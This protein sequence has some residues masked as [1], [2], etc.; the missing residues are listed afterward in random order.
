[1]AELMA[2]SPESSA[3]FCDLAVAWLDATATD[4]VEDA[5]RDI[6]GDGEE[7]LRIGG[8]WDRSEQCFDGEAEQGRI[9]RLQPAQ[10]DAARYLAQWFTCYLTGDW[11]GMQRVWSM[12]LYGGRRGGKTWLCCAALITYAIA[13]PRSIVWGVCQTQEGTD[14]MLHAIHGLLAP[15]WYRF[16]ED[17]HTYY[18]I[19]GSVIKLRGSYKRSGGKEGQVDFA[20]LNEAQ[21]AKER[22]FQNLR[23]ASADRGGLVLLAFNPPEDVAGLWVEEHWKG[24]RDGTREAA[25]FFIDNE[26]NP[27]IELASLQALEKEMDK[28]TYDREVRGLMGLAL[29]DTVFYSWSDAQSI[30]R[31]PRGWV[32]CTHEFTYEHFKREYDFIIGQDFDRIPYLA[33]AIIKAYRPKK[34]PGAEPRLWVVQE[35]APERAE[36]E[37]HLDQLEEIAPPEVSIVIADASGAWQDTA[38]KRGRSSW[39]YFKARGYHVVYPDRKSKRN[40][41]IEERVKLGNARLCN[42]QGERRYFVHPRCKKTAEAL[43]K[44]EVRNGKPYMRSKYAHFCAAATYPLVRFYWRQ[45][46]RRQKKARKAASTA[47]GGGLVTR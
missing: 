16:V 10:R 44:W 12:C 46:P 5:E 38:R 45:G 21:K 2:R 36:E 30:R 33:S 18:L 20:V 41:P 22:L 37:G 42:A 40:P 6:S 4:G 35:C 31:I 14:E 11:A 13:V 28:L 23:G 9:V 29:G 27:H 26:R 8:R 17:E 3:R 43:R 25:E 39:D 24:A 19:N 7:L 32:D 1:M 15:E 47:G 34:Q